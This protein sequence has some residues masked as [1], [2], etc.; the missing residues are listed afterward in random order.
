MKYYLAGIKRKN[1]SL[2]ANLLS[3]LGY[4]VYGY[5]DDI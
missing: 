4:E 5:E 3:D 1:M 2:L